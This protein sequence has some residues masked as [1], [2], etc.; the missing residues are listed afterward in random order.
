MS[1]LGPVADGTGLLPGLLAH[2][3]KPAK[4]KAQGVSRM[5]RSTEN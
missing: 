4:S 2:P 1:K 5:D 3:H